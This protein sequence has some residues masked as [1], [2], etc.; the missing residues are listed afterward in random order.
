VCLAPE[1]E[2]TSFAP[3]SP[4]ND[5]VCNW[6]TFNVTV[7]QTV[8]V[9]WYL[10]E[11]FLLRN[12]SVR[13]ASYR[14]HAEVVGEHNVTA[15]ASNANGTDMQ[16]WVWNVKPSAIAYLK[17]GTY[18]DED[19]DLCIYTAPTTIGQQGA[20]TASDYWS[21]DGDT[22]AVATIDIDGDGVDEIAY[23]KKGTY[24]DT[25]Y[26]LYIYTAPT[27]IGEHGTLIASDYWSSDGNTIAITAVG[28]G[29]EIAYLKKGTYGDTDYD[30]CIYTAPT[31]IG[32]HGTLIA[33]DYWSPDGQTKGISALW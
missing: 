8:N 11:S 2:I 22:R 31:T 18:S 3:P 17:K 32:E 16:T 26:D 19:Y 7:N 24:G 12:E 30:L 4:V 27:A 25:D 20:Y 15:I 9:S 21:P 29:D 28:G 5:S 23:L 14:L 6:R 1:P 33:S 13:E 10:N